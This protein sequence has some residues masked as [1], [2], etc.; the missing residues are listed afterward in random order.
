MEVNAWWKVNEPKARWQ[1]DTRQ[2][3]GGE[4]IKILK[5]TGQWDGQYSR[6]FCVSLRGFDLF[7]NY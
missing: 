5:D 7:Y 3:K 6:Y 1:F 2:L 4:R